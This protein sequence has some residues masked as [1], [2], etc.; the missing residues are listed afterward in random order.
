VR[1][2]SALCE[3]LAGGCLALGLRVG[4]GKSSSAGT[5]L[6]LPHWSI[7]NWMLSPTFT[8]SSTL[9]I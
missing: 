7:S 5:R 3:L 9:P 8:T 4:P 1:P 2:A 6:I